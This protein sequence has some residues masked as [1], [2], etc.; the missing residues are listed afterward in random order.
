VK[1]GILSANDSATDD[2]AGALPG[3]HSVRRLHLGRD[4]YETAAAY[5]CDLVVI[6]LGGL[7][8][9]RAITMSKRMR[10]VAMRVV[11][12]QPSGGTVADDLVRFADLVVHGSNPH[13]WRHVVCAA[14]WDAAPRV[15]RDAD[16]PLPPTPDEAPSSSA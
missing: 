3:G 10:E 13:L 9:D 14:K 1:I 2:V 8:L 6:C 5:A 12:V 11:F 16:F 15:I 7:P 4:G